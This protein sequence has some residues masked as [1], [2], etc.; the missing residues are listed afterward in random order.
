M[1]EMT[2]DD[3]VA[4]GIRPLHLSPYQ[5]SG[6]LR[7]SQARDQMSSSLRERSTIKWNWSRGSDLSYSAQQM[8]SRSAR[9]NE[10]KFEVAPRHQPSSFSYNPFRGSSSRNK[11]LQICSRTTSRAGSNRRDSC[12]THKVTLGEL[13]KFFDPDSKDR[14]H[15]E[16]ELCNGVTL[17]IESA[18]ESYPN[19]S[20]TI[21]TEPKQVVMKR[22]KNR[23][24]PEDRVMQPTVLPAI[25]QCKRNP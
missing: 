15:R 4:M 7:R 25:G 2:N 11:S 18:I 3:C 23:P 14:Q 9:T 20:V 5:G 8:S 12:K 16:G 13:R 10:R 19:I 6:Q 24:I 1:V 22:F 17:N 21:K